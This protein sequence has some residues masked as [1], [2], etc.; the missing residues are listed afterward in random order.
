MTRFLLA[1]GSPRRR[2]LFALLHWPFDV[3]S[4]DVDESPHDGETPVE[5]VLRLAQA[6][7]LATSRVMTK[8]IVIAADTTVSL[9][10]VA[11]GKPR[12]HADADRMLRALR[13]RTHQV[14]TAVALMDVS[15]LT[16]QILSDL[17]T[18]DVPMRDY[19]DDEIA[20]YIASGDPLDKAGA[21]AIQHEGFHPVAE[22]RGCFANV[23][24]L[25]LCHLTRSLRAMHIEPEVDVP[26][27]CQLQIRYE[28]P[29]FADILRDARCERTRSRRKV[30]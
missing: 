17:A 16:G 25:P 8:G 10:G 26:A 7:A 9:D 2:E 5:M 15:R 24:G 4:A 18:T 6:K 12:D 28:C 14:H 23:M 21:Y 27:A 19:A 22:L 11:L 1:S 13:G 3:A 20:A 30:A 29:V